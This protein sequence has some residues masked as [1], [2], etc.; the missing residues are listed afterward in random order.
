MPVRL[1]LWALLLI[2]TVKP[3]WDV[4]NRRRF[5]DFVI[6]RIEAPEIH[7]DRDIAEHEHPR[8][9]IQWNRIVE[10][11]IVPHPRLEHPDTIAHEY[12]MHNGCLQRNVRAALAGYILR[13][14]NVDCSADHHLTGPEVHLWLRNR[15]ALYGVQ[16][17][18]IAPG[19]EPSTT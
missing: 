12:A 15:A 6:N 2:T 3:D 7:P 16:N 18:V 11:E 5:A 9:D 1:P 8:Q 10:M 14:W 17:L 4:H 13:R 19:Y